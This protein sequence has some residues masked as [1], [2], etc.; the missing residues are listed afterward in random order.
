MTKRKLGPWELSER[1]LIELHISEEQEKNVVGSKEVNCLDSCLCII[2]KNHGCFFDEFLFNGLHCFVEDYCCNQ[3][4]IGRK[5][6]VLDINE[7]DHWGT[8]TRKQG[9]CW[10]N[11]SEYKQKLE[12]KWMGKVS[13]FST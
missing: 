10:G 1:D 11:Y 7:I 12:D 6:V 9:D 5:V 3:L 4:L 8:T 13:T 2:D